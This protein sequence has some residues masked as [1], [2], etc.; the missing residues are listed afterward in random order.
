MN[1]QYGR[2]LISGAAEQMGAADTVSAPDSGAI[3]FPRSGADWLELGGARV[4]DW[5]HSRAME[6][7]LLQ[8]YLAMFL[9][10]ACLVRAD[11]GLQGLARYTHDSFVFLDGGWRVLHGQRP[12][13]DFFSDLGPLSYLATALGLKMAHGSAA[14]FAWVQGLAGAAIG[15]WGFML[16]SRRLSA[17]PRALFCAAIVL[18]AISPYQSG[19]SVMQTTPA[20]AYNRIGYSLVALVMLEASLSRDRSSRL[21]EAVGGFSSGFIGAI[22]LLLKVTYFLWIFPLLVLLIPCRAQRRSRWIGVAAGFGAGFLPFLWY[23]GGSLGPMVRDLRIVSGAK[24]IQWVWTAFE[25]LHFSVA[26]MLLLVLTAVVLLLAQGARG[27]TVRQAAL[28]GG[29]AIAGG[30]LLLLTNCQGDAMPLNAIAAILILQLVNSQSRM[31]GVWPRALVTLWG[32]WLILAPICL[33][34]SGLALGLGSKVFSVGLPGT[35]FHSARL[36]GI[37]SLETSY[38][39]FVD[40]GIALLD[41]HRQPGDTVMCLDFSNPFSFALGIPPA[42]GGANA[43]LFGTNF[44]DLH[45]PAPAWLLGGATL[46]MQPMVYSNVTLQDSV[47]RIYGPYL[48]AHYRLIGRSSQWELYRRNE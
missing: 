13:I 48:A 35:R 41:R 38:V 8:V 16:A 42:R 45:H 31:S 39:N 44:D 6:H 17:V 9:A 30:Y 40:D 14:G 47:P 28:I 46:V 24:H 29:A 11:I 4:L 3:S 15:L 37:S 23:A 1:A 22:L 21:Y 34:A 10:A 36:A 5:W 2:G 18:L 20:M 26:P 19:D 7:P 27:R 25:A 43:L 12:D 33:D 32:A